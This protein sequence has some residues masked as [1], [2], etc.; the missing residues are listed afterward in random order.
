MG[1]VNKIKS[2][3]GFEKLVIMGHENPDVD[4]ILSG[5]IFER[6]L[7]S[8][9]IDAKFII[10]D[11]SISDESLNIVAKSFIDGNAFKG[12]VPENSNLFLLDHSE[13]KIEGNVIGVIDHHPT[14]KKYKYPI[15]KNE[16]ASSTTKLIYDVVEDKSFFTRDLIELVLLGLFVDTVS[17]KN[18]KTNPKDI[19]W[20]SEISKEYNLDIQYL[21]KEGY[22]LTD[23]S[24]LEEAAI[25]GKKEYVYGKYNVASSYIQITK[26]EEQILENIIDVLSNKVKESNLDMWVFMIVDLKSVF[27]KVYKIEK[28]KISLKEYSGIMS[29][30]S[31][32]MP[33]IEK[34]LL[35]RK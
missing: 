24:D 34:E 18:S 23:I 4:S 21:I 9:G 33:I 29:R 17:M 12:T 8:Q 1:I 26:L 15:Y 19:P 31:Y 28:N 11:K 30:G 14:I 10:P 13:T 2:V 22:Y 16:R 7:I 6:Y 3:I 27:T 35:K 25:N 5:Y 20:V 32:V